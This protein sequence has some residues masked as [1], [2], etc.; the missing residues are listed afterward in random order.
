MLTTRISLG[1]CGEQTEMEGHG[2]AL[3]HVRCCSSKVVFV[4]AS[5]LGRFLAY[6]QLYLCLCSSHPPVPLNIL[7]G[8]DGPPG[9]VS[10]SLNLSRISMLNR[11]V[12]SGIF[13]K[14]FLEQCF[15]RC[16][17]KTLGASR[18]FQGIHKVKFIF[19]VLRYYLTFSSY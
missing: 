1:C 9:K 18:S 16:G 3:P 4:S 5:A 10:R 17:S 7:C 11:R 15:S 19:I 8:L 12:Y 14:H 6:S 2:R 13:I